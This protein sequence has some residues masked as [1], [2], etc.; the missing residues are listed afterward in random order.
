MLK[1]ILIADDHYVVKAGTALILQQDIENLVIDFAEYYW[2]VV[3]KI[4]ENNYDLLILDIEM[5]GSIHKEMISELKKIKKELKILIFTSHGHDIAIQYIREGADGYLH[6]QAM[7]KDIVTAVQNMLNYGN[8][9]PPQLVSLIARQAKTIPPIETLSERELQ[10][11]NLLTDGNGILE[12]SN[13]LNIKMST[14]S[15]YKKRLY[16]KLDINNVAELIS[17]KNSVH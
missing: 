8:Y 9:F 5:P 12:I 10:I 16:E 3:S 13:I 7:E 4:K 2:E 17:I 15:T 6:K 11:F 1:K 14:V